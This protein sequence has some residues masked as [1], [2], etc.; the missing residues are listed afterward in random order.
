MTHLAA[1]TS[2]LDEIISDMSVRSFMM[3]GMLTMTG[4]IVES[5]TTYVF[6]ITALI[7]SRFLVLFWIIFLKQTIYR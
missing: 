4:P 2:L 7:I 6:R 3:S 5:Q 1:P